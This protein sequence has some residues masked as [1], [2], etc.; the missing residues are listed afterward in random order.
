MILGAQAL[1]TRGSCGSGAAGVANA[2]DRLGY[3]QIDTISVVERAHNHTLWSR[4]QDF[5]G[6]L[7]DAAVSERRVFEYWSHAA[8]YLPID[9]FRFCLPRMRKFRSGEKRVW[10]SEQLS[11]RVKRYVFDRIRAEGPLQ[12]KDFASHRPGKSGGWFERSPTK[13]ALEQLFMEGRL[14]IRERRGFHKVYDLTERVLP[15]TIDCSPPTPTEFIRHL[16]RRALRA[17][18]LASAEEIA[19]LRTGLREGVERELARLAKEGMIRAVKIDGIEGEYF[20]IDSADELVAN[21]GPAPNAGGAAFHILSPFDNLVIQRKRLHKF[22]HFDYQIECYVPE[23]KRKWGY[24]CLPLLYGETFVGRIDAK[25]DRARGELQVK[26][27]WFEPGVK[28][29]AMAPELEAGLQAFAAFNGC[30]TV[31]YPRK[32]SATIPREARRGRSWAR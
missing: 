5:D 8:A 12:S 6:S 3:V 25:A 22:F 27:I 31:R 15:P 19:Y 9:D 26:K 29:K 14:M 20:A 13:V 23:A 2:V 16:I 32:F 18:G 1:T 10:S 17:H 30:E 7:L 24:F 11:P 28:P 21:A 4:V